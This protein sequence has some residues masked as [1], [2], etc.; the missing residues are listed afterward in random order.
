MAETGSYPYFDPSLWARLLASNQFAARESQPSAFDQ[1]GQIGRMLLPNI[2]SLALGEPG[3]TASPPPEDYVGKVPVGFD[4]RV[5]RAMMEGINVGASFLP[6]EAGV[7]ALL[8]M[9]ASSMSV[10]QDS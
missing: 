1:Q 3:P 2:T 7:P 10:P 6:G 8:R 4:P 9:A 5:P